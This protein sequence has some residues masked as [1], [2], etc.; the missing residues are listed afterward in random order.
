MPSQ[1]QVDML[2]ALHL[3]LGDWLHPMN[4]AWFF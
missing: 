4:M 2:D 1:I 3:E